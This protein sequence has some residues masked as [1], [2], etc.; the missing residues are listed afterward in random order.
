MIGLSC[1]L[2]QLPHPSNFFQ[3][4]PSWTI[5]LRSLILFLH[6]PTLWCRPN[7]VPFNYHQLE[8]VFLTINSCTDPVLNVCS[9]TGISTIKNS[10]DHQFFPHLITDIICFFHLMKRKATEAT[11]MIAKTQGPAPTHQILFHILIKMLWKS[12]KYTA[13][14]V[15]QT[16]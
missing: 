4:V 16:F 10:L 14:E 1:V 11:A 2:Q 6:F 9:V 3:V 13:Q 12:V 15:L 8:L 5:W 7:I